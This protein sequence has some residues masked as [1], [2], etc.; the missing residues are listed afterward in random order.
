MSLITRLVRWLFAA[1]FIA[2]TGAAVAALLLRGRLASRGGPNDEEVEVVA[3][4]ASSDLASTASPFRRADV[5]ALYGGGTLDLR[6]ATLAAEGGAIH[7]RAAFGGYTVVVPPT[8]HVE[9]RGIGIAGGFGDGRDASLVD[10][11][12]PVLTIDGWALFGGVGVVSLAPDRGPPGE[13]REMASGAGS[14][15]GLPGLVTDIERA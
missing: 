8:W 2:G 9:L 10:R 15:G 13:A 1:S 12:G 5:T 3:I 11:R 6:L 7:V 4:F 14:S